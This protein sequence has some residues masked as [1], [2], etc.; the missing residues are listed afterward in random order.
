MTRFLDG[1]AKGKTLML[2]RAPVMLRV[3]SDNF[4]KID[5]LDQIGDAPRPEETCYAYVMTGPPGMAFIDGSK[6][7]G[8]YPVAEYRL[9]N[10]QPEQSVMRDETAWANWANTEGPKV[11]W[12]KARL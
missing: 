5:A 10:P 12:V 3:V 7:R 8:R 9:V 11:D 6:C 2:K 1:A 4:G